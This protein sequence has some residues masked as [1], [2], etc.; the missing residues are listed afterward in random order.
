MT[1]P[2]LLAAMNRLGAEQHLAARWR[3]ALEP[4]CRFEIHVR[5]GDSTQ[6]AAAL[7][8]ATIQTRSEDQMIHILVRPQANPESAAVLALKSHRWSDSVRMQS[9]LA[10]LER[11]CSAPATA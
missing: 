2:Q 5:N 11:S 1:Q 9:L 4:V 8:G 10:H 7:E 3:Y 6:R